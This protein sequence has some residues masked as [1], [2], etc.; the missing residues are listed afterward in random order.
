[1]S[2]HDSAPTVGWVW[3]SHLYKLAAVVFGLCIVGVLLYVTAIRAIV[4]HDCNDY[5][6]GN[7]NVSSYWLRFEVGSTKEGCPNPYAN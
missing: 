2:K 5:Y 3:S 1:M 4:L 6:V 7:F